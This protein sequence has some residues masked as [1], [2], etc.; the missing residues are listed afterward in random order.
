MNRYWKLVHLEVGRFRTM[1]AGLMALTLI[2]QVGAVIWGTADALSK[3]DPGSADA[4]K[5]LFLPNGKLSLAL[6]IFHTRVLFILPIFLCIAALALYVFLIW[7]RDWIGGHTFIYRLLTLPTV[8]RHVYTAKATAIVLFVWVL[9][10]FQLLLLV[11]EN[12]IFNGMVPADLRESSSWPDL[13]DASL[14]L[15]VLLPR[16]LDQFLWSYG[17]GI[18]AVLAVFTAILL[19]RSYRR[20]GILYAI[21][22]L[23]ACCAAVVWPLAA[24]GLG[25]PDAYLYP[26]E[27]AAI[28]L[29]MEGLVLVAS[30]WLGFRLIA[31]KVTV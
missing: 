31:K 1:M 8:R 19:E 14:V 9:L 29:A 11:V 25:H 26:E 30:V 10:A 28:E 23:A 15:A 24:L 4:W 22:Y 20:L 3:R 2:C 13:I 16:H 5:W 12:L 6:V 21:L 7:Y 27:I 17:L 18:T